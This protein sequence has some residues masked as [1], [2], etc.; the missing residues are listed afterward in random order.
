MMFRVS[1]S[2]LEAWT[3]LP[4]VERD[5]LTI[6]LMSSPYAQREWKSG[7]VGVLGKMLVSSCVYTVGIEKFS[8]Y[9]PMPRETNWLEVHETLKDDQW[10][11]M[12]IFDDDATLASA[13]DVFRDVM[14]PRW[15]ELSVVPVGKSPMKEPKTVEAKIRKPKK[16][17]KAK[18]KKPAVKRKAEAPPQKRKAKKT[19]K[20]KSP[21]ITDDEFEELSDSEWA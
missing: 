1:R 9:T 13:D 18:A 8:K 19:T 11:K 10:V 6:A 15:A 3:C 17:A 12:S 5:F 21:P 14:N 2:A 4:H 7:M 20:K 16:N